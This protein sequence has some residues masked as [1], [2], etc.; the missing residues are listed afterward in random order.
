MFHSEDRSGCL[1]AQ[2]PSLKPCWGDRMPGGGDSLASDG[3]A[4]ENAWYRCS[5][6]CPRTGTVCLNCSDIESWQA[7]NDLIEKRAVT[8]D[9]SG[10]TAAATVHLPAEEDCHVLTHSASEHPECPGFQHSLSASS[11]LR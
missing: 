8:S 7:W 1:A 10:I 4:G 6:S 5:A 11:Q 9:S 3:A 2:Q